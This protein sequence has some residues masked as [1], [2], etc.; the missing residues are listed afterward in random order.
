MNNNDDELSNISSKLIDVINFLSEN[1]KQQYNLILSTM[2]TFFNDND[3]WKNLSNIHSSFLQKHYSS[4][5]FPL[6]FKYHSLS[7]ELL[8]FNNY[9]ILFF[10]INNNLIIDLMKTHLNLSPNIIQKI[11]DSNL[12]DD[13]FDFWNLLLSQNIDD[14]FIMSYCSNNPNSWNN[15]DSLIDVVINNNDNN[16]D[17]NDNNND[18]NNDID[19]DI[20]ID[21]DV[22]MAS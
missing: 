1:E 18:N 14:D 10:L 5:N 19:I 13:N 21:I 3:Y 17:N 2:K 11:I 9:E 7:N 6:Y 16:N 12:Y 22:K 8:T 20:D 15:I 4:I